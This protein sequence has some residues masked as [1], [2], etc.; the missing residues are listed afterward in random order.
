MA[1]DFNGVI[2]LYFQKVFK[3]RSRRNLTFIFRIMEI[4]PVKA[5]HV[6]ISVMLCRYTVG[7]SLIKVE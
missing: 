5:N 1:H 3:I 2:L 7:S 4:H 6:M